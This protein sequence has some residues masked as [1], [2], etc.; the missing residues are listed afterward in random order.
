MTGGCRARDHVLM[1]LLAA[2]RR[3]EAREQAGLA[4]VHEVECDWEVRLAG[5]KL[6]QE[7]HSE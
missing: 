6:C 1:A 2:G 7:H 5:K 3:E 4:D